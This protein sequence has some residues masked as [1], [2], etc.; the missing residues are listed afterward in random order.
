MRFKMKYQYFRKKNNKYLFGWKRIRRD[1]ITFMK[2]YYIFLE[3]LTII[4]AII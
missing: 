3:M 1:L 4:S 2:P